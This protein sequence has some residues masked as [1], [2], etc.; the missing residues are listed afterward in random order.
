MNLI[1]HQGYLICFCDKYEGLWLLREKCLC[2]MCRIP[3]EF[4]NFVKYCDRNQLTECKLSWFT[5]TLFDFLNKCFVVDKNSF[6]IINNDFSF[7]YRDSYTEQ[8]IYTSLQDHI[9]WTT[10][11]KESNSEKKNFDFFYWFF[12]SPYYKNF[13]RNGIWKCHHFETVV[14]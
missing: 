4:S 11:M 10:E 1:I 8:K 12:I 7:S 3:H 2:P 13:L 14:L 9:K 6:Q 5:I